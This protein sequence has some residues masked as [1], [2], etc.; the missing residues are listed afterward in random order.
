MRTVLLVSVQATN[1]L[2]AVCVF[3]SVTQGEF[4]PLAPQLAALPNSTYNTT[5][6]TA[7]ASKTHTAACVSKLRVR[8]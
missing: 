7:A 8:G 2:S 3:P 6:G 4:I 1:S 5:T